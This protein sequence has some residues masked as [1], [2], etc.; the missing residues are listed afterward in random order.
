MAIVPIIGDLLFSPK[1]ASGHDIIISQERIYARDAYMRA[2]ERDVRATLTDMQ[3][4]CKHHH[5][6]FDELE[7]EKVLCSYCGFER[8]VED[9]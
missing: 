3:H 4:R 1:M 2:L 8:P 6:E 9:K 7:H 5:F